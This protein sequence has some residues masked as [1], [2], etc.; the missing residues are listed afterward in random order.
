MAGLGVTDGKTQVLP[1][2]GQ[3]CPLCGDDG[4]PG[5]HV[6]VI[7]PAGQTVLARICQHCL[8]AV[9]G[10]VFQLAGHAHEQVSL[11]VLTVSATGQPT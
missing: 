5:I 3:A 10:V 6:P 2:T 1:L 11:A 4:S 7:T 9:I 8:S